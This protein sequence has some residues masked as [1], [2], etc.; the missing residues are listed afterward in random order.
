MNFQKWLIGARI[1]TLPA[2]V[3]PVLIGTALAGIDRNWPRALL[4]LV[5]SL[6]LQIAV[7]FANDYSDGIRGTDEERVG[8]T[9]LVASGLA[10]AD[11]VKRAAQICF[12]VAAIAGGILAIQTSYWLILVGLIAIAAAWFYTGGTNP[13]GYLGFGEISVFIFFG[14]VAT[15][16][17]FYVQSEKITLLSFIAALPM[18]ALSC[19]ILMVNNLRDREA[20]ELVGKRTLA[21]RIGDRASRRTFIALMLFAHFAALATLT[22]L[23]VFT[24]LVAPLSFD[25]VRIVGSVT[26]RGDF[27]PLLGKVGRL[28]LLFALFLSA[29]LW[30]SL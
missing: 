24:L 23:A 26:E 12:L 1:K 18:G 7:N 19:A 15:M 29:A 5:V 27:I 21:V 30:L 17:T 4:A 16:G 28:Q 25:V 22:P 11:S 8:P 2:A 13:Y 14:L 9:R 20:D 10:T 6:S 3:S